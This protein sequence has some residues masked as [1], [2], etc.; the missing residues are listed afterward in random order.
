MTNLTVTMKHLS[1][2][3][4]LLIALILCVLTGISCASGT[5]GE[6]A[7]EDS[8]YVAEQ[9][10]VVPAM[11]IVTPEAA[12][13]M[14]AGRVFLIA[15]YSRLMH[16]DEPEQVFILDNATQRMSDYLHEAYDYD[17]MDGDC[18]AWWL[19]LYNTTADV[20]EVKEWDVTAIDE[21]T[22]QVVINYD[23]DGTVDG[24]YEYGVK[25]GLVK[26]GETF[27]ID[28]MEEVLNRFE[29]DAV[30]GSEMQ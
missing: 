7:L 27:K 4:T 1:P 14:E 2:T 9:D 17:C 24:D 30:N 21:N 22:Y 6:K 16:S 25:L 13:Q 18:I 12:A 10:S 8:L 29:N 19:F 23:R 28:T 11:T 20:G 5:R 15:F 3:L 26:D